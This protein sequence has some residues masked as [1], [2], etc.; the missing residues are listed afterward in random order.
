MIKEN[1]P[2]NGKLTLFFDYCVQQLV[3]NRNVAIEMWNVNERRNRTNSAFEGWD[4][5]LNNITGK[6]RPTV[7][8]QIQQLE[9]EAEFVS[10]QLRSKATGQ[11]GQ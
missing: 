11:P 8:L 9:E 6:Q 3:E 7:F 1:V 5:K 10:W 2:Q 4:S